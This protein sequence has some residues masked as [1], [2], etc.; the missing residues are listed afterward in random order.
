[1]KLGP[2]YFFYRPKDK[3]MNTV[4]KDGSY[5]DLLAILAREKGYTKFDPRTLPSKQLLQYDSWVSSVVSL[6]S[7]RIAS[8]DYKFYDKTTNEE[9]TSKNHSYASFT[10]PFLQPND[11]MSFRWIKSFCQIQLDTCGMAMIY[12]ARNALG[13]VWELWPLNMI[14]YIGFYVDYGSSNVFLPDIYYHFSI[15]GKTFVFREQDLIILK[16]PHP[17]WPWAGCSPISLQARAV[18]LERYIEHYE[19]DFFQNSARPDFALT[20]EQTLDDDKANAIKERWRAIFNQN[21]HDV[22]VTDS[23]T[24]VVPLTFKNNDMQFVEMAGWT[25]DMIL[26]AYHT[27]KAK[28]GQSGSVNRSSGVQLDIEWNENC[29]A[30]RLFIWDDTFTK[31][32]LSSFNQRVVI[33]HD[34]P[35]PRDRQLET[36]EAKAYAG[37]PTL[38]PNEIRKNIHQVPAQKDG[39]RL[40]VPNTMVF[41]DRLDDLIDAQIKSRLQ[42]KVAPGDKNPQE[43]HENDKPH[44]NPDGSD[45]RDNNPTEGRSAD[46]ESHLRDVWREEIN[47]FLQ[48]STK[49]SF[50]F[51]IE[52]Y[53]TNLLTGTVKFILKYLNHESIDPP[54]AEEWIIPYSEK[55]NIEFKKTLLCD[56][57]NKANKIS[58]DKFIFNQGD[59]NPRLA[60][61]C[62]AGLRAA[63]NYAKSLVISN[64]PE[65]NKRWI[66][67][68]NICG[69][70]G[71]V[72]EFVTKDNF[73]IGGQR[74]K[75]PGENFNLNC[76][77][78]L[79]IAENNFLQLEG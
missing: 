22:A 78:Y 57:D 42:P 51:E 28:L 65:L 62:N 9:I 23:G 75:F 50:E 67:D 44:L 34:N 56:Y 14:D 72:K 10:K 12:P 29:I 36:Q 64:H 17:R 55:M 69:H 70:K 7:N 38:T 53:I 30:P 46:P 73:S 39:D 52:K 43:Q 18:D 71:R 13:Q 5:Q 1:M 27:N 63:I 32:V 54:I 6:I 60:K 37:V 15:L 33:R 19:K 31:K 59:S 25:E 58:W 49:N 26:A 61:I 40:L 47:E 4:N 24:T 48:N 76:D 35:I 79:G 41:L 3:M 2:L 11:L 66:I 8:V 21:F 77:C 74:I 16:Y 20:T 45:D 68:R